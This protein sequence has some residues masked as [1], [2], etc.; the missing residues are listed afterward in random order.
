MIPSINSVSS[1]NCVIY[2]KLKINKKCINILCKYNK[3]SN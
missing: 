1:N 2:I 3:I